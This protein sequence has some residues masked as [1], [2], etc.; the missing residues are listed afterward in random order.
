MDA[1]KRDLLSEW[2]GIL[3]FARFSGT[4]SSN[5]GGEPQQSK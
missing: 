4:G 3:V 5:C 1:T 2:G